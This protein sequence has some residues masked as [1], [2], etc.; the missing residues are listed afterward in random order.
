M[1]FTLNQKVMSFSVAP[2]GQVII[3]R[4]YASP[5][6]DPVHFEWF[7]CSCTNVHQLC[8]VLLHANAF[9]R[10]TQVFKSLFLAPLKEMSMGHSPINTIDSWLFFMG[11]TFCNFLVLMVVSSGFLI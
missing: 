5:F 1:L 11:E 4:M 7:M 10:L 3:Q 2:I 6:N 9:C 8:N